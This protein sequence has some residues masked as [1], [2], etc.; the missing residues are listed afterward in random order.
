MK[1]L[2]ISDIHGITKNL[3]KIRVLENNNNY[4]KIVNLGDSYY[5]G[6]SI[7]GTL[8]V[9]PSAVKAFLTG[10]KDKLICLR[11]NCDADVDIEKSQFPMYESILLNVDGLD[12]H[13]THGH[14]HNIN[15]NT[16]LPESTILIYG[17]HHIPYIKEE[18][19]STYIC[20]GSVSLPRDEYGATYT[21]YE[22]KIITIY[23]L[24]DNKKIMEKR[25]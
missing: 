4:D 22:N 11:G 5:C 24:I 13:C 10:I 25:F 18:Q 17:H 12:L 2:F 20:V 6:L 3:D 7:Q 16:N 15:K 21:I 9:N 23:S 8:E 19:N 14:I 1:I